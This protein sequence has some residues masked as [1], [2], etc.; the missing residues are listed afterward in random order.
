MTTPLKKFSF[1]YGAATKKGTKPPVTRVITKEHTFYPYYFNPSGSHRKLEEKKKIDAFVE[2]LGK[3]FKDQP[4]LIKLKVF[5]LLEI[6]KGSY[7][8]DAEGVK[9]LLGDEQ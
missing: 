6:L 9:Y 7:N 3:K 1:T 2:E 5:E 4:A 8:F